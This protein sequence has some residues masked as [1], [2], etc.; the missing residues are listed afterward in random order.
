MLAVVYVIFTEKYP[1]ARSAFGQK[2]SD[3][4]GAPRISDP[5]HIRTFSA[6]H[7]ELKDTKRAVWY[8]SQ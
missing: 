5:C 8:E 1:R 4:Y 7:T 3:G 6:V 2:R